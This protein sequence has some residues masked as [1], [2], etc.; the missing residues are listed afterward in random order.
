MAFHYISLEDALRTHSITLEVSGGGV[1]GVLN[2]GQLESVLLHI[3]NDEWY[4][5]IVDKLTHLFFCTNKFHCLQDGNKRLAISLCAQFLL[6]NGYSFISEF[7]LK[8]EN[9][10][11]HV[12]S[13][14]IDKEFLRE[15][16][17]GVLNDTLDEDEQLK[18]RLVNTLSRPLPTE[19]SN[20]EL[21]STGIMK[22]E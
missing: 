4:P 3:Q 16:F 19:I 8:M 12:A 10:S 14:M 9:I 13:G 1:D 20:T 7:C 15:L 17:E 6:I 22:R 5:T 18:L 11:Y 2:Q 21:G